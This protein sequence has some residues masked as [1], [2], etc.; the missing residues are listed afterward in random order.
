M[1]T[2]WILIASFLLVSLALIWFPHFRQQRMLKAEEAGVRKGTNLELFNERL[3]VLEKELQEDLLDQPEFDALK[4]E[5]EISLLQDMKQG[6]DESLVNSLKPKSI[7]WPSL[8]SAVVIGICGYMYSTLGAY[9]NLDQ[10]MTA[11]DPHAGQ[12]TE[13]IMSQRVQMMEAQ[14]QS[15][16]ENSQLWFNLGHAYISA[17]RYDDAIK[18]FD[19]T[20]DLVGVHAELLGPK[21][22]ALYYRSNQQMTPAVQALV[23]QALALDAEDPST[24]LLV[25]MDSF[26]TADYPKAIDA[27]Q[28][29]LDSDRTDVDRGAIMNAIDSAKMRM[30]SESAMPNDDAHKNVKPNATA[31][32]VTVEVSITPELQAKVASTDMLFIFARS[33]EGP[34]VPLAATKISAQTLPVT[35]TLDDSTNMGGNVKLSDAKS[36]EVIAILSKHGSVRAQAGDIQ[37]TLAMVKV[38]DTAQLVLD[39]QVQ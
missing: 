5:L 31:K 29:I 14:A 24:L 38:G 18:A 9:K 39:T 16:P 37:G 33:T 28:L 4:K 36:V 7:M 34:K 1:T 10:P 8:M 6:D 27:W 23:D 32:T 30:G 2:F 3:S 19:K 21:A 11:N 25:G 26:F 35:I 17:N 15:E 22:T 12:T 13:Q 20:M